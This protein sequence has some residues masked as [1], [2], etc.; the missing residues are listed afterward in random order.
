VAVNHPTPASPTSWRS[1]RL[2]AGRLTA[3]GTNG[4]ERLTAQNGAVLLVLLAVIGVTLLQLRQLL[5]VHLFVG[6]LLIGP[7]ALKLASTGYRFIRYY[8]AS[9]TYREKGP[10]AMLLRASAPLLVLSTLVVLVS[11]VALLFVGPQ[12]RDELLPIHKISFIVW[13][14]F[15]ALHVLAHVQSVPRALRA[16]YGRSVA[17]GEELPGRN[18]RTLSLAGA[19]LAGLVLALLVIPEFGPWLHSSALLHH[20]GG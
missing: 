20:H 14:A 5:W 11:G 9:P 4:N 10:P 18:G 6:M 15:M 3:G 7:V 13:A 2:G 1:G 17:L 19:L 8:T 12:S 16:D